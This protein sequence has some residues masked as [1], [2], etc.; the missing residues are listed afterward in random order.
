MKSGDKFREVMFFV[1][2]FAQAIVMAVSVFGPLMGWAL[3]LDIGKGVG[4]L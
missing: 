4:W 3:L 1:R 2:F